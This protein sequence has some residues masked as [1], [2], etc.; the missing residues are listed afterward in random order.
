MSLITFKG[1]EIGQ[2]YCDF[3][4]YKGQW[5]ARKCVKITPAFGKQVS[6][7]FVHPMMPEETVGLVK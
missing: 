6:N 2:E 7:G 1:V 5:V 3:V 4:W